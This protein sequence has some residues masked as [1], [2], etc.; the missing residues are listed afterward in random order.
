MNLSQTILQTTH[1]IL[2][3]LGEAAPTSHIILLGAHA[4]LIALVGIALVGGAAVML[5]R[6]DK[7]RW[8]RLWKYIER[9]LTYGF[10]FV[11]LFG[12]AVYLVGTSIVPPG[13]SCGETLWCLIHQAPMATVHAFEMFVLE[14]D[15]SAIHGEFHNSLFFMT[16]FSLVHFLAVLISTLFIIKYFGYNIVSKCRLFWTTRFGQSIDD[17]YVFWGMNEAT[18]CLANSIKKHYEEEAATPSYKIIIMNTTEEDGEDVEKEHTAVERLFRFISFKRETLNQYNDLGCLTANV[19][20]RLSR[21][22]LPSAGTKTDVLIDELDVASLARLIRKTSKKVHIFFLGNDEEENIIGTRT[23]CHDATLCD[24]PANANGQHRQ[25]TIYCHARYDSVNRVIE[26]KYSDHNLEVKVIDSS[27]NSVNILKSTP[28]YHPIRFVDIDTTDNIGTVKSEFCALVVGLGETG[29][30]AL[31]FLYEYGAFVDARSSRDDD[32]PDMT[33]EQRQRHAVVRSPF[34]CYVAD[35]EADRLWGQFLANA[36]AV[37]HVTPWNGDVGA[38]AFYERLQAISAKLN[39][40]VVALGNDELNITTAVRIF[41]YVRKHREACEGVRGFRNFKIFVRCHNNEQLQRLQHIADHYNQKGCADCYEEHIV[42][43]GTQ[44]QLYTYKQ[45]VAN[46]FVEAGKAYNER[47]CEASGEKGEKD[48]WTSRRNLLLATKTLDALSE[49]RRKETQDVANAYHALTKL[50]VMRQ[51]CADSTGETR[52]A[53]R[54][55]A[56]C[57]AKE[58]QPPVFEERPEIAQRRT[59]IVAPQGS[60]FSP[61]EVLLFRN[62]ARL[63]HMRWNASH[64]MMGYQGYAQGDPTCRLVVNKGDQRH[65]CNERYKLHNCLVDWQDLDAEMNNECNRWHSDY[66]RFDYVV[67]ATAFS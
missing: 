52:P 22:K 51:A 7:N 4:L 30:D 12:F 67:V 43:F 66:K 20:H 9:H 15:V 17:L 49:L 13:A 26:D 25:T 55:L 19:F 35:Q 58:C 32:H 56:A 57:L 38:A 61:E 62:L 46:A 31:R 16:C 63:E 18:Y 6:M 50:H 2:E 21:V 36:P 28:E 59:G 39:Y 65:A 44:D 11:W 47:Y 29:R 42:I 41:G 54:H 1:Q 64:E 48:R 8:N 33:P 27:H 5:Y 40:V 24:A 34:S 60:Q 10:A 3:K 23:L 53:M 14:S 45:V 37:R